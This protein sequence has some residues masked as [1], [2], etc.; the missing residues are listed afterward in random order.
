MV[1]GGISV[2][3]FSSVLPMDSW[4][5]RD[6][7]KLLCLS[8]CLV[9]IGYFWK[10]YCKVTFNDPF[11]SM[12][13]ATKMISNEGCLPW[14][15]IIAF[16]LQTKLCHMPNGNFMCRAFSTKVLRD[17]EEARGKLVM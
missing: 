7:W 8:V 2:S 17:E 16:I 13:Y 12:K 9:A 10:H 15:M 5:L 3:V 11:T 6:R 4:M 14:M 1:L